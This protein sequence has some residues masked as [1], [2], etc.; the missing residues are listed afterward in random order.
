MKTRDWAL[1]LIIPLGK[2][3]GRPIGEVY[4]EDPGYIRWLTHDADIENWP[5]LS[6]ALA[7]LEVTDEKR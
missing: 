7:F 6:D 3:K 2:Y 4:A 5:E 1:K